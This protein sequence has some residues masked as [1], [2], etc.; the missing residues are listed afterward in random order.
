VYPSQIVANIWLLNQLNDMDHM[1]QI[2]IRLGAL[3]IIWS[4]WLYKNDK[5]F[6][7]RF[8]Y[9]M[10]VTY[11]CTIVLRSKPSPWRVEYRDLFIE[12]STQ[13]EDTE[14]VA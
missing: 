9:L 5:I 13:W 10:N 3:T 1:F 2:V 14:T 8:F 11:R 4:L 6:N 7:D 12:V